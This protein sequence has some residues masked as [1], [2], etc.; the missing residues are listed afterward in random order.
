M[1][2]R[3]C[4]SEAEATHALFD[5]LR[6]QR[7][8]RLDRVAASVG[9]SDIIVAVQNTTKG[10]SFIGFPGVARDDVAQRLAHV[11]LSAHHFHSVCGRERSVCDF[12]ADVDLDP[13]D[14]GE[15]I[16][17]KIVTT[18]ERLFATHTRASEPLTV[19]ILSGT[20]PEKQ[21]YHVHIRS[22]TC[23]F[24]DFGVVRRVAESI[25]D[26]LAHDAIDLACY[27]EQGM[28][29]CAF[30][31]KAGV[32]VPMLPYE[33]TD[34]A[35]SKFTAST[36]GLSISEVLALSLITRPPQ[37]APSLKIIKT[38]AKCLPRPRGEEEIDLG[39]NGGV[40]KRNSMFPTTSDY[41]RESA[42]WIRYAQATHAV[43]TLPLAATA[44]FARW[45][46]V[47]LALHSFGNDEKA[48]REWMKFSSRSPEK[49]R[50]EVCE[51][52][53]REFQR[54]PEAFNWRRGFNYLTK[55]VWRECCIA[56]PPMKRL[57]STE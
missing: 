17:H 33:P 27:R 42:K 39:V 32:S 52:K 41:L 43:R 5:S 56:P 4:A 29:R 35:L 11:P 12:Y 21:S 40:E 10:F 47:G 24:E 55:T 25:N 48:F 6:S 22:P 53:W 8:F 23:A 45:V 46:R 14:K 19:S 57:K 9:E 15:P 7:S 13:T 34:P 18:V 30:S 49:Y 37:A 1:S 2:A 28:L 50:V 31:R 54:R 51:K 44:D 36:K 3:L 26:D 38:T 20:T 16:L